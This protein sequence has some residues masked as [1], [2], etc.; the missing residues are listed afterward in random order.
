MFRSQEVM[1]KIKV[2]H[3]CRA[4]SMIPADCTYSGITN[5]IWR[6]GGKVNSS[7]L[8]TGLGQPEGKTHSKTILH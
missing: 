4:A 2:V 6:F 3:E 1:S 7:D 5:N 8:D